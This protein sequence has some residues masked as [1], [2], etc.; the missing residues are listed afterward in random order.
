MPETQRDPEGG[1]PKSVGP[2]SRRFGRCTV[3]E[4]GLEP[5]HPE[6]VTQEDGTPNNHTQVGKAKHGIVST[7]LGLS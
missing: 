1:H 6:P 7:V 2:R 5:R 3:E 4:G